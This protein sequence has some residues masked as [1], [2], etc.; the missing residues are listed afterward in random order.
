MFCPGWIYEIAVARAAQEFLSA[1]LGL[2]AYAKKYAE[3]LSADYAPISQEAISEPA[4]NM[5]QFLSEIEAGEEAVNL[6]HNFCYFRLYNEAVG[7]PRK[8]RPLFGTLEAPVKQDELHSVDPGKSFRAFV[9]GFRSNTTPK[10]PAGWK[11]EE[12]EHVPQLAELA[13]KTL[14]LLD[15]Y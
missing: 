2:E 5:L 14:S 4:E 10:P 13:A 12:D 3:G 15:I 9:F 11:L 1:E 7:R 8:M 6:L